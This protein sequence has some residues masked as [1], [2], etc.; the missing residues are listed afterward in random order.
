MGQPREA[1]LYIS[2]GWNQKDLE[3][4]AKQRPD[5]ED[6]GETLKDFKQRGEMIDLHR[7]VEACLW[8]ILQSSDV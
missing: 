1:R 7:E 8:K 6:D 3:F 4:H 2:P 5:T